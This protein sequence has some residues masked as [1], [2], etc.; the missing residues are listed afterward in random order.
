MK[1]TIAAVMTLME[2]PKTVP[3]PMKSQVS[4][5]TVDSCIWAA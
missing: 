2:N 3:S 1:T 5:V 4:E